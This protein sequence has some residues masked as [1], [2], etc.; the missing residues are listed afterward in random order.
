MSS[1][2]TCLK[3][4]ETQWTVAGAN[5]IISL[6]T[7]VLSRHYEDYWAYRSTQ[8]QPAVSNISTSLNLSLSF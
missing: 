1:V 5:A 3:R 4:P 7:C 2:G 8:T 6:R